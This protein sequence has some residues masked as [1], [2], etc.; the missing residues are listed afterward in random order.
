MSHESWVMT[1]QW[2][3]GNVTHDSEYGETLFIVDAATHTATHLQHRQCVPFQHT[4]CHAYVTTSLIVDVAGV[5][6]CVLSVRQTSMLKRDVLLIL[7]RMLQHALQ[8]PATRT[9][10]TCNTHCNTPGTK[11]YSWS[12]VCRN[13]THG[14]CCRCV[15][16]CVAASWR[17]WVTF[18]T[19]LSWVC[20]NVAHCRCC[21][22][23]AVCVAASS[24]QLS[25]V[26]C[27]EWEWR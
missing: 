12:G 21:R 25:N 7:M 1:W 9:A 22:C 16:V 27:A 24:R 2:V 20:W 23:V 10:D 18:C 26:L 17:Q 5:L 8:T 14:R 11:C 15:A 6:Q 13:V 19:H 3:C 4:H